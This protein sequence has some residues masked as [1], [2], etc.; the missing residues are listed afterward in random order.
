MAQTPPSL[1]PE[2]WSRISSGLTLLLIAAILMLIPIGFLSLAVIGFLGGGAALLGLIASVMPILLLVGIIKIRNVA[3]ELAGDWQPSAPQYLPDAPRPVQE[4]VRQ[5]QEEYRVPGFGQQERERQKQEDPVRKPKKEPITV[6]SPALP[7]I[8]WEQWI[9]KKLLQK[10]G[11]LIVLI[12]MVVF[13]KYSFDNRLIGELGRVFLSAVAALALLGAGEWFNGKYRNWSQAFTGAGLVLLY[14]TVWV[15]DVFY[16]Q[17]LFLSHGL[18]LSPTVAMILYSLIT[19]I[20]ALAAIRY[21]AQIIA[22]FSMIGGYLTPFLLSSANTGATGFTIYLA[23]L[24]GGLLLLAWHQKWPYLSLA[25]FALTQFSLFGTIYH[26]QRDMGPH[27]ITDLQQV[28]IAIGF[29]ILFA[30][31][32]LL[33][34]FKLGRRAEADDIALILLD[35]LAAFVAVV[36]ATGGFGGQYVG[37]VSLILAAVYMGFSALALTRRSE[38]GLLVNTYLLSSIGLVALALFA[39]MKTGWVAAGWAPYSVLLMAVAITLR[40]RS[41]FQCALAVLAGSILFLAAN[42]PMFDPQVEAIWHP[43]TSHWALLSYVVFPCLLAWVIGTKKVPK[44]LMPSDDFSK[45]FTP[46][47]HLLIALVVFAAVTFEATGLQWVIT[48]PLAFSYLAF[49]VG[50]VLLFA[51][52]G[53]TVWFLAAVA[54]QALVLLFT[55]GLGDT[56]G[57]VSPLL[58]GPSVLPFLHPWGA[59]SVLSFFATLGLLYAVVSRAGHIVN[60]AHTRALM[61]T[62]ACVQVWM[63]VTVEIQHMQMIHGWT[64]L[65]T[66]RILSAWWILFSVPFFALALRWKHDVLLKAA[67]IALAVPLLKDLHLLS[68]HQAGLYEVALWTAIPLVLVTLASEWK[69]GTLLK[70]GSVMLV[71]TMIADMLQTVASSAGILQTVWWAVAGLIVISIGFLKREQLLRRI[72]MGIFAATVV[73]LLIFDFAT[74]STGVRI[75]ASILTGLLLIGASYLYQ[76][77]DAELAKSNR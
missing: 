44:E 47:I 71:L 21:K 32:P 58:Q 15:A 57:M 59:V 27:A 28:L 45:Q 40:R 22:W 5:S 30:L 63:H 60:S 3:S 65:L 39:Q 50:A 16:R 49:A 51:W 48:L 73:K 41:V 62:I 7:A 2:H 66:H 69:I 53:V 38:D 29:F 72:A 14:F 46:G 17:E 1:T 52:T 68:V 12:G 56:S 18:S 11:I 9:G 33:S 34:Q 42:L 54:A 10:V 35:G 23:I 31:P 24:A 13:L 4:P 43:F 20:G 67:I 64:P 26:S 77:F 76:R 25:A 74:L 55:F 75:G 36:N 8:D 70:A 37:L 6:P 19:G 61:I